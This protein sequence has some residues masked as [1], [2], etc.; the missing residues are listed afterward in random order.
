[1]R[2]KTSAKVLEAPLAKALPLTKA[3]EI[4]E[5]LPKALWAFTEVGRVHPPP[6]CTLLPLFLQFENGTADPDNWR[7][8]HVLGN[9]ANIPLTEFIYRTECLYPALGDSSKEWAEACSAAPAFSTSV[10]EFVERS[11]VQAVGKTAMRY[12]RLPDDDVETIQVPPM[13]KRRL[14]A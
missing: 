14:L 4:L 7:L 6:V 12:V 10:V 9:N 13:E 11:A 2:G 8:L 5:P 1:M 3:L